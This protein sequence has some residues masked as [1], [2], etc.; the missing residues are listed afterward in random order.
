MKQARI[1]FREIQKSDYPALEK[2]IAQTWEYE[3]YCSPTVAKQMATYYLASCLANQTFTCVAE[4]NGVAVGIIL[5][6]VERNFQAPMRYATQEL[7]ATA[8][9]KKTKEGRKMVKLYDGFD[10]L[11]RR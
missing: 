10:K 2:M 8:R 7:M 3:R 1:Q 4:N 5:G 11:N 9:L 6:K